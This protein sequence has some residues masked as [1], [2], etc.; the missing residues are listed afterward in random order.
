MKTIRGLKRLSLCAIII[1]ASLA[2]GAA[3]TRSDESTANVYGDAQAR[4]AE[5]YQRS[6]KSS[7]QNIN[8]L[9]K[10][11]ALE[12]NFLKGAIRY[13]VGGNSGGGGHDLGLEFQKFMFDALAGLKTNLPDVYRQLE[14][15]DLDT[16]ASNAQIIVLE[17]A[18]DATVQGYL[19]DSV[20]VNLPETQ[21]ILVNGSRWQGVQD[22][23]LR[24][25]I[26][27]HELLSLKKLESTG[28]YPISSRYASAYGTSQAKL[29]ASLTLN[30]M[31]QLRA[32]APTDE[33]GQTLEKFY[34]E[35]RQSLGLADIQEFFNKSK[36]SCAEVLP[37]ATNGQKPSYLGPYP[38]ELNVYRKSHVTKWGVADQPAYG[39]LIPA[40]QG[41]PEERVEE[42]W[43]NIG[44]QGREDVP[45]HQLTQPSPAELLLKV[46]TGDKKDGD[47]ELSVKM[48]SGMLIYKTTNTTSTYKR[49]YDN[50]EV[51]ENAV[52]IGYGYC[53]PKAIK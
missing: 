2:R 50:K 9:L 32:L 49:P 25:G 8:E 27:L 37:L 12:Q 17:N 44:Y 5:L 6:K 26:A 13:R 22:S 40:K 19:Q 7:S 31:Q 35:A 53:Y 43:F 36:Y 28:F 39:P 38:A 1:A 42:M 23:K 52:K 10:S 33:P 29:A 34:N 4:T 20:A 15:Y 11:K 30:R 21:I 51:G 46:Q 48:N 3:D 47:Y 14:S 41:T 45:S 16:V 18:L 24:E